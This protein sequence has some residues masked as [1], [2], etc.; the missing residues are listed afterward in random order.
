MIRHAA[1]VIVRGRTVAVPDLLEPPGQVEH[2]RVAAVCRG[3]HRQVLSRRSRIVDAPDALL[4]EAHERG[5]IGA[6]DGIARLPQP[7]R[8]ERAKRQIARAGTR[9]GAGAKAERRAART[10]GDR[11]RQPVPQ[12]DQRGNRGRPREDERRAARRATPG[13]EPPQ[14]ILEPLPDALLEPLAP[15]AGGTLLE[16]APGEDRLDLGPRLS[17]RPGAAG[18]TGRFD[19]VARC[20]PGVERSAAR[21]AGQASGFAGAAIK[22]GNEPP[23]ADVDALVTVDHAPRF[24]DSGGDRRRIGRPPDRR[25][26]RAE[27][28]EVEQKL[29][30]GHVRDLRRINSLRRELRRDAPA[31]A[32]IATARWRP[33]A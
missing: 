26:L 18:V 3:Q 5:A 19:L 13:A 12:A 17:A 8:C 4:F 21:V 32:R 30:A 6:P 22:R 15:P 31:T 7:R 27:R 1:R 20:L 16:F 28:L 25:D 10:F 29:A 24:G 2:H 33:T 14:Q 23:G 9:D 11:P